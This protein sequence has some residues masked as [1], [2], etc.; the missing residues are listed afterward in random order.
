MLNETVIYLTHFSTVTDSRWCKPIIIII[1]IIIVVVVVFV[2]VVSD[3]FAFCDFISHFIFFL[4]V[5]IN[6]YLQDVIAYGL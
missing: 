6:K 3:I 2:V 1:I 5:I 4:Y